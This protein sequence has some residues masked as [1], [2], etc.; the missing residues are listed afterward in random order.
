MTGFVPPGAGSG[1]VPPGASAGFVP[2]APVGARD[3]LLDSHRG[4]LRMAGTIALV[5]GA[6]F[7]CF[8]VG[9]AG[10][11]TLGGLGLI[12]PHETASERFSGVMGSA[13]LGGLALL[14]GGV[15]LAAGVGMRRLRSWGRTAGFVAAFLD[16]VGGCSCVLTLAFGIWL[17]VLL[18][19][20]RS[21]AAFGQA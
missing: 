15:N 6:L 21:T 14:M 16:L 3:P 8:A 10:I 2:P 20:Q 9:F 19:D 4:N 12:D 17:L 1:F 5:L 11:G 18:F 7:L 13:V